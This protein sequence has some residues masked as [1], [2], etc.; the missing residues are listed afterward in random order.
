M[1]SV[2]TH[3]F[4]Q[5]SVLKWTKLEDN[6]SRTKHH[7]RISCVDLE[8]CPWNATIISLNT[9]SGDI[10]GNTFFL[11]NRSLE[12]NKARRQHFA[13]QTSL[14]NFFQSDAKTGTK[15]PSTSSTNNRYF[16][17]TN[18]RHIFAHKELKK[19]TYTNLPKLMQKRRGIKYFNLVYTCLCKK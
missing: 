7:S 15:R 8:F 10:N 9:A 12:I 3:L 18:L 2:A 17:N 14:Q 19:V 6:T 16:K 13:Y 1:I 4:F 11:L 5:T